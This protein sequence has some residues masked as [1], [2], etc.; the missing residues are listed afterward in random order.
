MIK[1]DTILRS[2]DLENLPN[3]NYVLGLSNRA[4]CN[5]LDLEDLRISSM[6]VKMED[7]AKERGNCGGTA[8]GI[9]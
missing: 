7:I 5:G 4:I 6:R 1:R 8:L 2:C 9:A 3:S